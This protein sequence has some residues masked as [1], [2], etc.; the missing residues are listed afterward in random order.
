MLMII[1]GYVSGLCVDDIAHLV[2]VLEY[3]GL[4]IRIFTV[5]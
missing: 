4:L 5:K 3:S 1:S 2:I